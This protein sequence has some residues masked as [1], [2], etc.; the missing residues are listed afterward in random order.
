MSP[1]VGAR[2]LVDWASLAL[3]V[4]CWGSTFAFTKVALETMAPMWIVAFRLCIGL[5]AVLALLARRGERLPRNAGIWGWLAAIGALALTPFF[6]I[7]WGTRYIDTNLAGILFG[8]GPLVTIGLAHFVVAGERMTIGRA[9]GFLVGF[10]GLV[11][12]IGPEALAGI[13][14]ADSTRLF[15]QLA[16]VGAASGYALQGICAKI[17]P[18]ISPVQKSA[19]AFLVAAA[20][21]IPLAAMTETVSPLEA[22]TRSLIATACMG[23]FSTG[24]AGIVMFRLI[25]S[26]GPTF[27][28]LT[29]YLIPIFVLVVGVALLGERIHTDSLVAL[30]LIVLGIAL[31]EWHGKNRRARPARADGG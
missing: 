22:S 28:S 9:V 13:G 6:L 27:L 24:L 31:S 20:A 8:I 18:D 25:A 17:M 23:V 7:C 10:A 15:A 16:L 11:I 30:V 3:L 4:A 5:L 1:R 19:G 2:P 12:L 14:G 29:N 21:S 26:A